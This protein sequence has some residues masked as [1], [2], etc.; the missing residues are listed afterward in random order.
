VDRRLQ[1]Q[2]KFI[3]SI[4]ARPAEERVARRVAGG[5]LLAM[6]TL[7]ATCSAKRTD[8]GIAEIPADGFR[9]IDAAHT[10]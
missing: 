8:L 10:N 5:A 6:S 3:G 1:T 2:S 9:M 4:R 7:C